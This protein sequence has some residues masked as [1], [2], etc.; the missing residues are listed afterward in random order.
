MSMVVD[1]N[2]EIYPVRL[3]EKYTIAIS[4]TLDLGGQPDTGYFDQR[5]E[6]FL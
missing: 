1:I 4:T 2:S 3:D 5:G 6:V